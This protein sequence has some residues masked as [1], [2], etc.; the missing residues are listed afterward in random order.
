MIE[1]FDTHQ[2]L[3]L[4][5][6]AGYGWTEGIP[7]LAEG[8][9]TVADYQALTEG[10]G[11]GGT[12]FMEAAVDEGQG[13]DETRMVA[14]IARDPASGIRGIISSASPESG[15]GFDE[16]LE[17]G[18]ELGVVGYRRV[19]HVVDDGM[20]KPQAFR[21]NVR[22]VGAAGKVFDLC[23]FARQLPIAAEL[24]K[25]CDNTEMVLDHCGVPD[26]AAG[27]FE[28]WSKGIAEVAA[29]NSVVACKLSGIMA[30]CKPGDAS[31]DTVRPYVDRVLEAFGPARMVWGSDWPVVDQGG[32]LQEWIDVTR[33]ILSELSDDEATQIAS[34]NAERIYKV[35]MRPE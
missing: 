34:G 4:R 15:E 18:P 33:K 6:R 19:L 27:E 7:E 29:V 11:V 1:L 22:K 23:F 2:H 5:D 30:Y 14:E 25:A 9:F 3:I 32:G 17:E 8:D 16:W 26:I 20:S 21:D 12:L 13:R 24:A 10:K 31:Y 35:G 28:S